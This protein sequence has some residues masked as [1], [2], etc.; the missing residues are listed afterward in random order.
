LIWLKPNRRAFLHSVASGFEPLVIQA[1]ETNPSGVFHSNRD[2]Q[3]GWFYTIQSKWET[4]YG[5]GSAGD[6]THDSK[7]WANKWKIPMGLILSL[8]FP[9]Y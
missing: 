2:Y 4:P 1:G 6:L 7:S 9:G 5:V 3:K 8:L